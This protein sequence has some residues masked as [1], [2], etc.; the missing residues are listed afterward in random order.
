MNPNSAKH[1]HL[2]LKFKQWAR[3]P[4]WYRDAVSVVLI[5]KHDTSEAVQQNWFGIQKFA[6]IQKGKDVHVFPSLKLLF[7]SEAAAFIVPELT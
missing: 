2:G 4:S 6:G 3:H 7:P 1:E 5:L